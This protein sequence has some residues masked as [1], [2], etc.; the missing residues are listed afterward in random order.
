M[1]IRL[2]VEDSVE[3]PSDVEL[4]QRSERSSC[5]SLHFCSFMENFSLWTV[6]CY[7]HHH[8]VTSAAMCWFFLVW[9]SC[10]TWI[11]S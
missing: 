7:Y 5:F 10:T 4:L 11:L 6:T 3:H 8:P 1:R 2:H 9:T